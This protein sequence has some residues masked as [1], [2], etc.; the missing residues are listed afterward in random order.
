MT[1]S[2]LEKIASKLTEDEIKIILK[3]RGRKFIPN[4]YSIPTTSNKIRIGIM[5]DTHIGSKLFNYEAFDNLI[6][7]FKDVDVIYFAGDILEGMSGR[8]GHIY[9]LEEVG[10]T[11]QLNKAKEL[12]RHLPKECYFILG[13]HDLWAMKKANAGFN[14]GLELASDNSKLHYLG[15]LEA[16]INLGRNCNIRLTH[17]GGTA[18]ALSYW[19]QKYCNS[20]EG[21]N[22][23]NMVING[24]LHKSIYFQYR[25][26]QY[27]EAGTLQNQSEFMRMKGS[28]VSVGYWIVD[29]SFDKFGIKK[30]SPKWC[31]H[32]I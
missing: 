2:K 27:F 7:D 18:Y 19:G 23:P 10:W 29:L 12:L 32:F 22:K 15:D 21:G 24:H 16:T 9:E 31:P 13:N 26:I 8:E 14:V 3:Q 11:N 20:L 1:K 25:N 6:K 28:P 30:L 5:S 4:K 17:Y